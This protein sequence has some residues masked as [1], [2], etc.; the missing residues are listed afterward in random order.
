MKD[1]EHFEQ[2]YDGLYVPRF[3]VSVGGESI[4]ESAGQ[5]S[6]LRIENSL[7]EANRA[8]FTVNGAYDHEDR[9]F[10]DAVDETYVTDEVLT[11][12]VGYADATRT[13][14]AGPIESVEPQFDADSGASV[15]VGAEDWRTAMKS[16]SKDDSWDEAT[17]GEAVR[18]VADEYPFDVAV[19]GL[20]GPSQGAGE[21]TPP[22]EFELD[23]IVR[24]SDSDREFLTLLAG[25]YGYEMFFRGDTFH[26]RTPRRNADEA[27]IVLEYG[28]ALRSFT[29]GKPGQNRNVRKVTVTDTD[30]TTH[31]RISGSAS[32][33]GSG[34]EVHRT[35]AVESV[36]EAEIRAE[37][38]LAELTRGPTTNAELVGLPD[39]AV[40]TPVQLTGLTGRFDGPYYVEE[41]THTIG[42]GGYTTRI[43][44]REIEE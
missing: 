39:V 30:P 19:E 1:L 13:V 14:F 2:T 31:E 33:G 12:E 17:V 34:E 18:S 41:A 35:H 36:T 38:I 23:K 10:S 15:R 11:V 16:T 26:F 40:G 27:E 44:T 22:G 9:A 20:D 4:P 5:I 29:P 37:A 8:T 25:R 42:N 6:G 32:T 28:R 21:T 43:T 3:T 24:S 7:T